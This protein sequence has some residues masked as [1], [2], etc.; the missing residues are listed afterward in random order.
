MSVELV[1]PS[2]RHAEG[3]LAAE[4]ERV[5][6]GELS[7]DSAIT[8]AALPARLARWEANRHGVPDGLRVSATTLW[9]VDGP[10]YIG[11]ISIRHELSDSLRIMGGHIGYDVRPSKR[12]I[13]LGTVMLRLS[14]R[15]AKDLGIDPAMLTCD[16]TNVASRRMIERC[17]GA[18]TEE[19]I[20]EGVARLRFSLPTS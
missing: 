17:G 20:H 9:L 7:A 16:A 5:A 6:L 4:Q 11:R 12:G 8:A 14:L 13:G 18:I 2:D 3:F 1:F 10:E 15:Y 19:Y